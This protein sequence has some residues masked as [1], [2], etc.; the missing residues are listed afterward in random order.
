M[1]DLEG[2]AWFEDES[3]IEEVLR[4]GHT[5]REATPEVPGYVELTEVGRGGQATVYKAVQSSTRRDVALKVFH[6]L[7][8]HSAPA[9]RR[10]ERE[11]DL[12]SSLDH[13]AIVTL[14][15]GGVAA[16][17][18][19]YLVMEFVRGRTLDDCDA[20][21]AVRAETN[22]TTTR[23]V[24][25]LLRELA[26]A[27]AHAHVRGVIHRDLKPANILVGDDGRPHILDFGLARVTADHEANMTR[28]A[29][30]SFSG[31]LP[32]ASPEQARG[33]QLDVRSDVYSLGVVFYEVL[34][35]AAPYELPDGLVAALATIADP[36]PRRL[37]AAA[38]HVDDDV[39]ALVMR[40]L[41]VEPE[42]RYQSGAELARDLERYL[43]GEPIEARRDSA[44]YV[45]GRRMKRSRRALLA[46]GVV[47]LA[48][49]GALVVSQGALR[50]ARE[51]NQREAR[52]SEQLSAALDAAR[53]ATASEEQKSRQLAD[54]L[55]LAR[56]ANL[57]EAE[58][59]RQTLNALEWVVAMVE[60]VDPDEDGEDA[61]LVDLLTAQ[62]PM[63]DTEFA[64]DPESRMMIRAAFARVFENLGRFT[65]AEREYLRLQE[66]LVEHREEMHRDV[67]VGRANVLR[68]GFYVRRDATDIPAM[69]ALVADMTE[70]LGENDVDTLLA[71][72]LLATHLRA[73]GHNERAGALW[74]DLIERAPIDLDLTREAVFKQSLASIVAAQGDLEEAVRL[75]REVVERLQE[76]VGRDHTRALASE[77]DLAYFLTE[78]GRLEEAGA[79]YTDLEPRILDKFGP[80]HPNAILT[81]E[82]H[83][84]VLQETG[85]LEGAE[86]RYAAV[87]ATRTEQF[88]ADHP[89]T[90]VTLSNLAIVR[91]LLG[92]IEGAAEVHREVLEIRRRTALPNSFEM[93][94][95]LNSYGGSLCLLG[96]AAEALPLHRDAVGRAD[97]AFGRAHWANA[98]FRVMLANC[99]VKLGRLDEAEDIL[100]D[101]HEVLV[102]VLG[103][104]HGNTKTA[105][106]LMKELEAAFEKVERD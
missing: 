32:W 29:D 39:D 83:A 44:W 33:E 13:P 74:R 1:A 45:L 105:D 76:G 68:M 99:L 106:A 80:S 102:R 3:A 2:A 12:V 87:L 92:D 63:L 75:Q 50:T 27:V 98:T 59:G 10:F 42:R 90:L 7:P 23:A 40:C 55:E 100:L 26:E 57:R 9:L 71:S 47:V 101:A 31:S 104:D 36:R 21:R 38:P 77:M 53:E 35:G 19:P 84:K 5:E 67:L 49:A 6:D 82:N 88:G 91:S 22:A 78:L 58:K 103:P 15:D 96:R 70:E 85:D 8:G 43:E 81:R 73:A 69:E 4:S 97:V 18:R 60:S 51:A 14:H 37:G 30:G 20:V 52:K 66:S 11:V 86:K 62:A 79:L 24:V 65:D 16:D 28:S 25:E 48:L 93:I 46:A 64:D 41:A 17:G 34:A 54:A 89:Q 56:A 61:R 72:D 95:A 94:N